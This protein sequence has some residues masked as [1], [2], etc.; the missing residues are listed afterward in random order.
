MGIHLYLPDRVVEVATSSDRKEIRVILNSGEQIITDALLAAVGRTSNTDKLRLENAGIHPAER[1][2][3]KVNEYYQT[4]IPHIYAAGDVIGFPA[5]CSTSM[6]QGR[7]AVTHAFQFNYKLTPVNQIPFGIWTI[8]E[9]SMVGETEETLQAK[10]QLYIVGKA[11]YNQNPRGMVLGDKYGLVK[12]IFS[13]D[14]LKLLG[15]HIIGQEA[16]ELIGI[17]L[18][19]LETDSTARNLINLCFNFPS[20]SDMYKYAAYDAIDKYRKNSHTLEDLEL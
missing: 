4:E 20:L 16:C 5:L 8:P 2:L 1:G 18:I 17:G 13:A 10:R 15:V 6:E 9:I 3:I 7:M 12:L 11:R 14:D 19:A